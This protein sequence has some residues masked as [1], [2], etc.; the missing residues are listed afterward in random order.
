MQGRKFF[1]GSS[2]S[3]P[4]QSSTSSTPRNQNFSRP[5]NPNVRPNETFMFG[6]S[7][8]SAPFGENLRFPHINQ[9]LSPQSKTLIHNLWAYKL[10]FLN[11][12]VPN[13]YFHSIAA[14]NMWLDHLEKTINALQDRAIPKSSTM[15]SN[16]AN[17]AIT[18]STSTNENYALREG[19]T[20]QTFSS[21]NSNTNEKTQAIHELQ[22]KICVLQDENSALMKHFKTL[23]TKY[24]HLLNS[25]L[26]KNAH[27]EKTTISYETEK[28][29]RLTNKYKL[30]TINLVKDIFDEPLQSKIFTQKLSQELSSWLET[31]SFIQTIKHPSIIKHF[32]T[33][34]ILNHT[35][36]CKPNCPFCYSICVLEVDINL[37]EPIQNPNSS[38]DFII[39]FGLTFGL[40]LD[41]G[42]VKCF[43][44]SGTRGLKNL[45][46][47][48]GQDHYLILTTQKFMIHPDIITTNELTGK[49]SYQPIVQINCVS[50]P[51]AWFEDGHFAPAQHNFLI[52]SRSATWYQRPE[53]VQITE[54][55]YLN[56]RIQQ[57]QRISDRPLGFG[58]RLIAQTPTARY[59]GDLDM[60][61]NI[62]PFVPIDETPEEEEIIARIQE[63]RLDSYVLPGESQDDDITADIDWETMRD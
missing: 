39:Q 8:I 46:S 52:S 6:Q 7:Q 43:H 24:D 30:Q 22:S 11:P 51:P 4:R 63:I 13:A 21:I 56:F 20:K 57:S 55:D 62:C 16:S 50:V 37:F 34:C 2:S 60:A 1:T 5:I 28:F 47:F 59:Y 15:S 48:L 32:E 35:V 9:T 53:M 27:T 18:N 14:L 42:L 49:P 38:S 26:M 41:Y 33:F 23:K 40:L 45:E 54:K 19:T 29:A 44:F 10:H 61:K 12:K 36:T 25:Q 17:L 58:Y 31:A 3:E